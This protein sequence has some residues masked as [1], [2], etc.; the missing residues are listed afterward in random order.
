MS[1]R[2]DGTI[3]DHERVGRLRV[4]AGLGLVAAAAVLAWTV[5]SAG[6]PTAQA[7]VARE[8]VP[9]SGT[10]TS[11]QFE[12][13]D[14]VLPD[15]SALWPA[16]AVPTGVST[17]SIAAG[18]PL[19]SADLTATAQAAGVRRVTLP[20]DPEKMPQG[21]APGDVVDVWTAAATTGPLIQAVVV[22]QVSPP[23]V[24]PG[25]VE[26]AVASDDVAAA[27]RATAADQVVLARH[28]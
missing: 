21:L 20:V 22:Q 15:T 9:E 26:V 3:G 7:W 5:T 16:A 24:G 13:V 17:R 19:L 8:P 12:L 10:A 23:D 25:R 27:V 11:Q 18:Q 1:A 6:G 4:V 2:A 28:P 14:V